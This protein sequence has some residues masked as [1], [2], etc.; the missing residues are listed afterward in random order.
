MFE[1]AIQILSTV[2]GGE[3]PVVANTLSHLALLFRQQA[4][5][6]ANKKSDPNL[7]R[8]EQLYLRALHIM[9]NTYGPE[10]SLGILK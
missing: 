4:K 3:D 6:G 5:G 7:L 9:E 10:H 1:K 8:A 2:F